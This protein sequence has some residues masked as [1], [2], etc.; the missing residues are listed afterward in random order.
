MKGRLCLCRL[1]RISKV[2]LRLHGSLLIRSLESRLAV[3]LICR[4]CRLII[5]SCLR[6]RHLLHR[7]IYLLPSCRLIS[8]LSETILRS[9]V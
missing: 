6:L 4:L 5:L 1:S 8:L 2:L 9:I 3:Q 7:L